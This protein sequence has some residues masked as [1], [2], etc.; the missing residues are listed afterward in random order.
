MTNLPLKN[1]NNNEARKRP[2][3]DHGVFGHI[4]KLIELERDI[5]MLLYP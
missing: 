5:Y 4:A 1:P 2:G 3:H